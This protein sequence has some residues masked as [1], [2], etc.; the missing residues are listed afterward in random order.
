MG[1][2]HRRH[3]ANARLPALRLERGAELRAR[4]CDEARVEP[5]GRVAEQMDR[6][7][8]AGGAVDQLRELRGAAAHG[9]GGPDIAEMDL[10]FLA[11][12][13][14]ALRERALDMRKVVVVRE[15]REY[16]EAR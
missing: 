12:A 7:G 8:V 1:R 13:L 5:A 4:G 14:E 16:E 2:V 11:G 3:A 6:A 15:A 9:R 10:C